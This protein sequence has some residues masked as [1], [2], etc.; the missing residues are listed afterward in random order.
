MSQKETG[1]RPVD[2]DR[3]ATAFRESSGLFEAMAATMA[4]EVALAAS[5]LVDSLAQGGTLL[6]CG[7]GGGG[8]FYRK[9]PG[10][11]AVALTVNS[12][13][14]TAIGNDF[15]YEEIFSR[16]VEA[17]G[18]PGDVLLC[19]TT[20]GNSKNVVLAARSARAMGIRVIGLT[21]ANGG[22]LAEH[23]DRLLPVP[24]TDTPRIQEGHIAIGHLLCELVEERL[25]PEGSDAPRPGFTAG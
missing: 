25:F 5:L 17:L 18:R 16:Q 7:N 3:I 14:L 24:S 22:A 8:K 1:M 19:I 2:R 23:C 20:S 15:A 21:G 9:R 4:G 6:C 13:M 12:S 10:L 11:P